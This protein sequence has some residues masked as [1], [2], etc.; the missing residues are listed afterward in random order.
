MYGEEFEKELQTPVSRQPYSMD[1]VL[2]WC[3]QL[4]LIAKS[5]ISTR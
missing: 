2:L 5:A 3:V 1:E 4:L